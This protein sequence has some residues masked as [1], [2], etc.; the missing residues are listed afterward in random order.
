MLPNKPDPS[1]PS[2]AWV[3]SSSLGNANTDTNL[4]LPAYRASHLGRF[5]PYARTRRPAR[6]EWHM[7]TVDHR[8]DDTYMPPTPRLRPVNFPPVIFGDSIPPLDGAAAE[9]PVFNPV[10]EQLEQL[11]ARS[12]FKIL[13]EN[14]SALF[15]AWRRERVIVKVEPKIEGSQK[16]DLLD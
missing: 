2:F 11:K 13:V 4:R 5:H 12:R 9:A 16:V 14:F 15:T 10:A 1:Y 8:F 7:T 6:E 3:M